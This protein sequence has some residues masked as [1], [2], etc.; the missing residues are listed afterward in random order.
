MD[1][2]KYSTRFAMAMKETVGAEAGPQRVT[3]GSVVRKGLSER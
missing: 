2:H 3:L 1:K